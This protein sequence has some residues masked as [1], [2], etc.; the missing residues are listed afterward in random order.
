[1]HFYT[2][3]PNR[4]YFP[5][6]HYSA[7]FSITRTT[8][9]GGNKQN[10]KALKNIRGARRNSYACWCIYVALMQKMENKEKSDHQHSTCT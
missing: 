10:I 4:N 7:V 9:E 3:M 6:F 5:Y 8:I 1:M 2:Q